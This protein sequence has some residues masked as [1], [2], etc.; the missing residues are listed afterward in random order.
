MF[1]VLRVGGVVS[2]ASPAYGVEEMAYALRKAKARFVFTVKE[3][4]E[5]AVEA[6]RMVGLDRGNVF[7]LEGEVDGFRNMEDLLEMGKKEEEQVRELVLR[8]GESNGKLCGFLS[9]SSGTT[10]LPK[11]VSPFHLLLRVSRLKLTRKH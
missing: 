4:L 8:D 1:A 6:A 3:R 2:G 11:A 10:G 9:F 7:I 5:V